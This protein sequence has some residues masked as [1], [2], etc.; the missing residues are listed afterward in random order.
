MRLS[1][2]DIIRGFAIIIMIFANAYPYLYPFEYCP[3]VIR[4]IFSSAAPTFV[5]LA[6]VSLRLAKENGKKTSALYLRAFQI[7]Y[8]AIIIDMLIWSI[9]PFIT[10]DVLYLISFS[11]LLT[12]FLFRF[13]DKI[14][15]AIALI[16]ITLIA[17]T[18]NYYIFD[19]V[20]VPIGSVFSENYLLLAFH[21]IFIDG[22]FPIF[23]WAG[24][25]ILGYI[26]C[27]NRI[28]ILKYSRYILFTGITC[29]IGYS[30]LYYFDFVHSNPIRN[31]Y[32]EMFYPVT[33]S[34]LLYVFGIIFVIT[35]FLSVTLRGL[36]FVSLIG[37]FSLPIYIIHIILIKYYIHFFSLSENEFNEL[38][39]LCG[40]I[41][42]YL[43][44]FTFLFF[45]KMLLI[46][47]KNKKNK[48]ASFLLGL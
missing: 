40:I 35:S 24:F 32:T 36:N 23:P 18:E 19:L 9:F 41:T 46:K 37:K 30:I 2:I 22:W 45:I 31:R 7:L 28:T 13:S 29:V 38:I 11:L 20:E 27:K 15:L 10:M 14:K 43:I 21:H 47:M 48:F 8:F 33:I 39:F 34:F 3:K 6:G 25:T 1:S 17:F 42:L 16:I 26:A 12:I 4:L 44:I 5:F